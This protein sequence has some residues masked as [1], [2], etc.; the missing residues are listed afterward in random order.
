MLPYFPTGTAERVW[1][2]LAMLLAWMHDSVS[3]LQSSHLPKVFARSANRV[4]FQVVS[5][6]I[7]RVL[8]N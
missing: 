1:K 2:L 6:S 3:C 4:F 8:S 5:C 7:L